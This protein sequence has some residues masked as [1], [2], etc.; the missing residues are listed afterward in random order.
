MEKMSLKPRM[1]DY[2]TREELKALRANL[3]FCG[4]DK[5]VILVT[6]CMAGEGKSTITLNLAVAL[7]ELQKKVLLVDCDLRKS[8]LYRQVEGEKPKKGLTHYL[9]GQA[10]LSEVIYTV[11]QPVFNMIFAG[12]V[13]PNPSELLSSKKFSTLIEKARDA[14]DYILIDCAPLG[15]VIDAAV[16]ASKSDAGILVIESGHIAYRLARNVKEQLEKSG[17]P[18]IGAVLNRVEK[19][20]GGRYYGKRYQKAYDQ[21]YGETEE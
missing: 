17:C 3:Q 21:Y 7:A 8:M 20:S 11:D 18:V 12:P 2:A 5:K 19:G 16:V 9:S 14:Y 1:Q 13:P 4:T 6:S 10:A 15:M